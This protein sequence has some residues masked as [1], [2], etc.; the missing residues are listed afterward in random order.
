MFRFD[1]VQNMYVEA[2]LIQNFLQ[3]FIFNVQYT[4]VDKYLKCFLISGGGM[5]EWK[6]VAQKTRSG[7]RV[8]QVIIVYSK[9]ESLDIPY[10]VIYSFYSI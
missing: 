10:N 6:A 8:T 2:I 7:R 9:D 3:H 1:S 4:A 5:D